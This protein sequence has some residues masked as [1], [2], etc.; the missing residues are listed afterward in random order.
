MEPNKKLL[1]DHLPS[2]LQDALGSANSLWLACWSQIHYEF[3]NLKFVIV[4]IAFW[5]WVK[6]YLSKIR[7]QTTL[8][9]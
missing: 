8:F 2:I 9:T 5:N 6:F 3:Q 1:I 4:D 7:I